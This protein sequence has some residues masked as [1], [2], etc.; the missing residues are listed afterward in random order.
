MAGDV[1][2]F[3][4]RLIE[5]QLGQK[6][7]QRP[8]AQPIQRPAPPQR[9]S[10]PARQAPQQQRR[11][12]PRRLQ[13]EIIEE[14]VEVVDA[15]SVGTESVANHVQKHLDTGEFQSRTGRLGAG[16]RAEEAELQA[17]FRQTFGSGPQGALT[18]TSASVTDT[19]PTAVS[20]GSAAGGPSLAAEIRNLIGSPNDLRR[21]FILGEILRRPDPDVQGP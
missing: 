7:P 20:S 3:L 19:A 18:R 17:H 1:E 10:P 6:Q 13:A 11:P 8:A 15:E 21:A 14:D 5:K 16:V 9:Q 12:V 2:D 4:R